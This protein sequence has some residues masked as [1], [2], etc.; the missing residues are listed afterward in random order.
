MF[1]TTWEGGKEVGQVFSGRIYKLAEASAVAALKLRATQPAPPKTPE[2]VVFPSSPPKPTM[3]DRWIA[4]AAVTVGGGLLLWYII[5][6][7]IKA[8]AT[9]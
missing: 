2:V 5:A 3:M 8:A 9:P 6:H 4:P 1:G 7:I